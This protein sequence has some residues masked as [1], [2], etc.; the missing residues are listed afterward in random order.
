MPTILVVEDEPAIA[1]VVRATL[2]WAGYRVLVAADGREALARLAAG[3]PDL[4]LSDVMLPRL[5]GRDLVRALRAEPAYATIP[6]ALM[7]AAGAQV[8]GGELADVPFLR[9]PFDLDELL[10]LVARLLG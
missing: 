1:E 4:V 10:A 2:E 8:A 7:S 6:V 9:K 5:D 3:R